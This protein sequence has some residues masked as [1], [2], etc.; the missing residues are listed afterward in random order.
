MTGIADTG[1]SGFE[2]P[3]KAYKAYTD[4]IEDYDGDFDCDKT[5]PD[6]YFGV[7]NNA[8][9]KV[10]GT[11]LRRENDDGTCRLKITDG[12]SSAFFGSP[13]MTGAFVVFEHDD[14]KDTPR[15]GWATA[16]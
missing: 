15:I 16:K 12:G 13:A 11:V 8:T 9:I 14:D 6:F 1:G 10:D 2:V 7:G 3:S 4:A 5:L